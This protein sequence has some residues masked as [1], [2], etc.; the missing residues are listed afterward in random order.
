MGQCISFVPAKVCR[1]NGAQQELSRCPP[2]LS[3]SLLPPLCVAPA[4]TICLACRHRPS[5]KCAAWK[6]PRHGAKW[7]KSRWVHRFSACLRTVMAAGMAS[8]LCTHCTRLVLQRASWVWKGE[9]SMCRKCTIVEKMEHVQYE[10]DR[11]RYKQVKEEMCEWLH[12]PTCA[13]RCR[14]ASC[15]RDREACAEG[16]S[17]AGLS[18]APC[19]PGPQT[20]SPPRA[21]RPL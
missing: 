11:K 3:P 20:P 7:T 18:P 5:A 6:A 2:A 9:H 8:L 21:A 10:K 19:L 15:L 1:S 13:L 17:T 4:A 12:S 16:G 14:A